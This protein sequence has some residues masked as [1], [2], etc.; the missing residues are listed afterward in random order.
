MQMS[1]LCS[2]GHLMAGSGLQEFLEV[3][4]ADNA[5]RQMLTGKTISRAV[6]SHM[7]IYAALITIL[8]AKV[9]HIAWPTKDTNDPKRTQQ[10]LIPR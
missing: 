2:I 4:F 3:V 8:V 9:Y 10:V 1:F 5:I 6:C 7:L